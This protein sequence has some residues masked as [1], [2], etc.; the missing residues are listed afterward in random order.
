[1]NLERAQDNQD[2]QTEKAPIDIAQDAA[3]K[4]A[5]IDQKTSEAQ[6]ANPEISHEISK[7]S[8]QAKTD[9]AAAA[10]EAQEKNKANQHKTLEYIATLA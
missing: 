7:N 4:S 10:T 3:D 8:L 9:I 2:K 5:T 6:K 1:M